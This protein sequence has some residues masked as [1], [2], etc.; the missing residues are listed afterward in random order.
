MNYQKN[1]ISQVKKQVIILNYLINNTEEKIEIDLNSQN[2]DKKL[3][4]K[5]Y[6]N[7]SSNLLNEMSQIKIKVF[8]Y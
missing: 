6:K 2:L 5:W 7:L 8:S 4:F 3:G 1:F